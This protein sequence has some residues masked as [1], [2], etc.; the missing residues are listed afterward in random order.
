MVK[1]EALAAFLK[2]TAQWDL[3]VELTE[4]RMA[5]LHESLRAVENWDD[6]KFTTG[7]L[8]GVEFLKNIL[9]DLADQHVDEV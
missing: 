6:Y 4:E 8:A 9:E 1:P 5:Q 2:D 7:E 3:I